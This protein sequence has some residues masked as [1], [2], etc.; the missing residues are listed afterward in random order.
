MN[1]STVATNHDLICS[2]A[3]PTPKGVREIDNE[4]RNFQEKVSVRTQK[5]S[6]RESGFVCLLIVIFKVNPEKVKPGEGKNFEILFS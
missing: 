6:K 2:F 4:I 5:K 3:F 1:G